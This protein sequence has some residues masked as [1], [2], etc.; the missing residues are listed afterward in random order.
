MK[1]KSEALACRIKM[2]LLKLG[3]ILLSITVL[4]GLGIRFSPPAIGFVLFCFGGSCFLI[5]AGCLIFSQ[6]Y[7]Q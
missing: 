5:G 7:S 4:C 1:W 6:P 3:L 2:S